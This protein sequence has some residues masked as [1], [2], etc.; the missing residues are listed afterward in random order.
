MPAAPRLGT[1]ALFPLPSALRAGKGMRGGGAAQ[2]APVPI[3]PPFWVAFP[4]CHAT[5]SGAAEAEVEIGTPTEGVGN[6]GTSEPM[7]VAGGCGIE[8]YSVSIT[9]SFNFLEISESCGRRQRIESSLANFRRKWVKIGRD[10]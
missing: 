4:F 6:P 3:P 5:L 2:L 1:S 7:K 8:L 9:A 10:K